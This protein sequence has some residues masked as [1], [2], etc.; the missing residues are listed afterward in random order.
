V[1]ILHTG[2]HTLLLTKL[3]NLEDI[4][5]Y[6]DIYNHIKICFIV[7]RFDYIYILL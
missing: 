5:L 3:I 2:R 4:T 1:H 6:A 7:N